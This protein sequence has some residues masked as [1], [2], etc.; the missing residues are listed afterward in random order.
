MASNAFNLNQ[1]EKPMAYTYATPGA[2]GSMAGTDAEKTGLGTAKNIMASTINKSYTYPGDITG[3]L[4]GPASLGVSGN[5]GYTPMKEQAGL[6]AA[7]YAK[8]QNMGKVAGIGANGY[9]DL[10]NA[11][12]A[13]IE[14]AGQQQQQ[15]IA[16]QYGGRGLYGSVGGGLMSG[17]Q[18][19]SQLSTQ[20]AL[21]NAVAQRY[22]L[23]LQDQQQQIEQNKALAD[24][25]ARAYGIQLDNQGQMIDQNK[26]LFTSRAGAADQQNTYNQMRNQALQQNAQAQADFYNQKLAQSQQYGI[27]KDGWQKS[28]DE[29]NFQRALQLA[30]QGN[31]GA[32]V[33]AGLEN[34]QNA[35]DAQQKAALYSGLGSIAGGLMG[36]YDGSGNSGWNFSNLW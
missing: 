25:I 26:A 19:A 17:A 11:L 35:T 27:N 7:D 32:Q 13:P 15:N 10:Q 8:L 3:Q 5:V 31:S 36:S 29:L 24:N 2:V 9:Q 14:R 34:A 28:I 20:D 33:Q 22:G 6:T 30:G 12:Q 16:A 21:S 4:K 18:A 23:Q 1:G